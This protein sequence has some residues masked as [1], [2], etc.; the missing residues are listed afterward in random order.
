MK[1]FFSSRSI[2]LGAAFLLVVLFPFAYSM[3]TARWYVIYCCWFMVVFVIRIVIVSFT[4]S[5]P[6]STFHLLQER[7]ERFLI[8]CWW[9]HFVATAAATTAVIL[10]F[11]FYFEQHWA[12]F[13]AQS[14]L[15]KKV[16]IF[17]IPLWKNAKMREI[18]LRIGFK[19]IW[20]ETTYNWFFRKHEKFTFRHFAFN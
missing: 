14:N 19:H 7:I 15:R 8:I 9:L 12:G 18:T 20:N 16:D 10:V 2:H 13:C 6:H 11:S 4:V 5:G 17:K 3:L 1:N